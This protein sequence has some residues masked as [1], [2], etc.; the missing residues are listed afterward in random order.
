MGMEQQR[1][2]AEKKHNDRE[3]QRHL[4]CQIMKGVDTRG[5]ENLE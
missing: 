1:L 5:L 2:M 4:D 3:E